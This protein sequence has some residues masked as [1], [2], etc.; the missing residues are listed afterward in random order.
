MKFYSVS[1]I[2]V[3]RQYSLVH[4][5]TSFTCNTDNAATNLHLSSQTALLRQ[6]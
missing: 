6:T 1:H 5:K 2:R 4:Q 3:S